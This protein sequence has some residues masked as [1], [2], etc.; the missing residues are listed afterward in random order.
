[1]SGTYYDVLGV[2]RTASY[3]EIRYAYRKLAAKYH[4][5]RADPAL[6]D[7]T[8]RMIE[9]NLA[10]ETLSNEMMRRAYDRSLKEAENA[11]PRKETQENSNTYNTH[12]QRQKTENKTERPHQSEE[13]FSNKTE[14][15]PCHAGHEKRKINWL[16]L[17]EFVIILFVVA[18]FIGLGT[19]GYQSQQKE[20]IQEQPGSQNV[21]SGNEMPSTPTVQPEESFRNVPF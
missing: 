9:I 11:R 14:S 13:C 2:P 19:V 8:D 10:Y 16:I 18:V 7:T 6:G 17:F 20:L 12:H 4:P 15:D 5:D 21:D 1:M 3:K